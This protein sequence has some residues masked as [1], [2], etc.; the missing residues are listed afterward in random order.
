MESCCAGSPKGLQIGLAK[1]SHSPIQGSGS[2]L[3]FI[4]IPAG[5]FQMGSADPDGNP[6]DF[7]GPIREIDLPEFEISPTPITNAQF[8]QFVSETHYLTEAEQLGWSFVFHLLTDP[9]SEVI[10]SSETAPWWLGVKAASWRSASG[11]SSSFEKLLEHPV[12]HISYQDALAFCNWA[13]VDLPTE[14]QWEK[15]ARG[16]LTSKRYPWGDELLADGKWQCNIFQGQFPSDNS[17]EDG[18]VGTSPVKTYAP[19]NFGGYDFSGNV[20]EWT[21]SDFSEGNA[22]EKV[23]RGGSYVCHD[24]YCNRY[25]VGARNRTVIDSLAGNIGFRVVRNLS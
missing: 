1:P 10:G 11:G 16:G 18:F 22:G 25:R 8:A 7:E 20:W 5:S 19:N 3:E 14:A 21:C 17:A 15:A 4:S 13:G 2:R 12:V 24:S 9:D 23:T 6:L